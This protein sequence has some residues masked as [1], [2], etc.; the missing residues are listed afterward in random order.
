MAK[1][2]SA[3]RE[4]RRLD[5]DPLRWIWR[6]LTSVRFALAL[7]GFLSLVA[8]IGIAIPQVPFQM[9]GNQAAIDAWLTFQSEAHFGFL[10]DSMYRLGLFDIFRSFWFL[11]GLYV[12]VASVCVCT[13][14]RLAPIWRNISRPQTR[15][16]DDYFERGQPVIEVEVQSSDAL[17]RQLRRRRYRVVTASEGSTTYLFA[18]RLP[19]AQMATF[20]SHLA[21]ILFLAGGLVTAITS[22]EQQ[23]FVAEGESGAAVFAPTDR[24]HM[25]VYVEDAVG[26]FDDEGFPLDFRTWLI[27]YQ[28]GSEVARGVTTVNDPLEYGGYRFHQSAYFPD[29]AALQIRDLTSGRLVYDEVLALTSETAAPRV[30]VRNAAGDVL[31]DDLI[32]PTDFIADAAGTL[33]TV[34]GTGQQFWVG[35]QRLQL[36]ESW[37]LIVLETSSQNGARG[38][39]RQG[40][41]GELGGLRFTF[42]ELSTIPST[43]VGDLP[44][45]D[46]Q[47]VVELSSGPLGPLLTLGPV[48]G[49]AL[50]LSPNQAVAL[51]GYEYTFLGQREFSGITVRR[52]PGSTLIWIATGLFLLGLALTFYIPRRRLWGKITSGQAAFRGLGGRAKAIEGEVRQAAGAA[53]VEPIEE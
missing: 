15:V 46:S 37:Q 26:S 48:S 47:S 4:F 14:N 7:I 12:L 51:N 29:G 34:P 40:E 5:F 49:R 2:E 44:G 35:A 24:D 42:V 50:A 13:A 18:D 1:A 45:A 10:T 3:G 28:G 39:I 25:Q 8:V 30:V 23:I 20:I 38:V 33:I 43:T 9:R 11:F 16:P 53:F 52:D 41:E 31:V 17:V 19:W 36:T 32:V 6:L 27:V 22:R 21:L